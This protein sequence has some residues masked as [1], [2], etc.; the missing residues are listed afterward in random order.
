V[1]PA[2]GGL[3]DFDINE[4]LCLAAARRAGLIAATTSIHTF[5]AERALVVERYDRIID[6]RSP[7]TATLPGSSTRSCTTGSFWPPTVTP[8]TTP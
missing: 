6:V 4:H 8:R 1:K 2:I 5:G 3:D 7:E